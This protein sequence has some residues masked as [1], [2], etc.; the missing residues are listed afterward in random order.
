MVTKDRDQVQEM[1]RRIGQGWSA[2][3]RLDIMRDKNVSMRLTRKAFD[4]C[5][6][7]VT[8]YMAVRSG[9]LATLN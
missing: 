1:K 9:R 5:V 7:P 8:I 6:L 4:E 3:C 2:F